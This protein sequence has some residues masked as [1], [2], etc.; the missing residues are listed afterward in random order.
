M[1]T[2]LQDLPVPQEESSYGKVVR[3]AVVSVFFVHIFASV[4]A[5][6]LIYTPEDHKNFGDNAMVTAIQAGAMYIAGLIN[7]G[8]CVTLIASSK[9]TGDR[10]WKE[11]GLFLVVA[12]IEYCVLSWA[13]GAVIRLAIT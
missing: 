6:G 8:L 3:T 10:K 13:A 9:A 2:E 12:G 5:F 4:V 11:A 1:S 7:I